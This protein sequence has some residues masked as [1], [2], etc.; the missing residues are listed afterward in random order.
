MGKGQEIRII[1]N[2]DVA[3]KKVNETLLS[4]EKEIMILTSSN[5]VVRMSK[6]KALLKNWQEKA[7]DVKIMA[8]ITNENLKAATLLSRKVAIRHMPACHSKITVV[9]GRHLFQFKKP[10]TCQEN[11][12]GIQQF[13]GTLYTNS[14]EF[15]QRAK[16]I[17][18]GIWE[19]AFDLSRVIVGSIARMP[20]PTVAGSTH[21]FDVATI[22]AKQNIGA[23]IVSRDSE[24]LGIVT[25]RDIIERVVL[26][27]K[28]P[29]EVVAQEIMTA[30]ILTIHNERTIEKA[31][32][33]MHRN[34]V[35][36]LVVVKGE[37]MVGLVTERRLTLT[38]ASLGPNTKGSNPTPCAKSKAHTRKLSA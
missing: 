32:E 19:D 10:L 4:A 11:L 6:N 30:P 3:F 7:V 35:R 23:V 14:L 38:Q 8:P 17:L 21:V 33:I 2:A 29:Q 16:D 28:N 25:E 12:E 1:T 37:K 9:D 15:V 22:M 36:R 31:L 13:E 27:G 5:G 34:R 18:N 26:T 20:V 24:P